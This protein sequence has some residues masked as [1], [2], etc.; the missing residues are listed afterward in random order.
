MN[1]EAIYGTSPWTRPESRTTSGEEVRFTRKGDVLYAILLAR[2]KSA[3]VTIEEL[4]PSPGSEIRLVGKDGTL[5]WTQE[6]TNVVIKLPDLLLES[7]AYALKI[8]PARVP[9]SGR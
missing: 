1:G 5:T 6:G 8:T 9:R 7:Y 2:P 4:S 3:S